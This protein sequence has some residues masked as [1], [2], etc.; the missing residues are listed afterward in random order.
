MAYTNYFGG[1]YTCL[2]SIEHIQMKCI[3]Y[4]LH[5]VALNYEFALN[6]FIFYLYPQYD[7][8]ISNIGRNT[9]ILQFLTMT[10]VTVQKI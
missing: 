6:F 2:I 8:K 9:L 3:M 7:V 1:Q 4:N 5:F 10:L